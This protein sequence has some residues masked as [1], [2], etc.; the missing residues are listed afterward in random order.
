MTEKFGVMTLATYD[1]NGNYIPATWIP[2]DEAE[3]KD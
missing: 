2:N 3:E 1:E